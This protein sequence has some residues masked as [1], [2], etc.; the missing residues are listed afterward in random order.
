MCPTFFSRALHIFVMYREG[1]S[2]RHDESRTYTE[3]IVNSKS[4]FHQAPRIRGNVTSGLQE[5]NTS[6]VIKGVG[7]GGGQGTW[8]WSRGKVEGFEGGGRGAAG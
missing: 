8:R 2:M 4:E 7:V 3:Q 1:R 5:K 6:A